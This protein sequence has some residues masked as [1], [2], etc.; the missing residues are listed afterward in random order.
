MERLQDK[1]KEDNFISH[2]NA[3][4]FLSSALKSGKRRDIIFR[5]NSPEAAGRSLVETYTLLIAAKPVERCFVDLSEPKS[6][7]S[8]GGK[9]Y[10]M[11]VRD[12]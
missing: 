1:V 8:T 3:W 11:I 7:K 10:M 2:L 4:H 5:V 9:E 12:D 6:V